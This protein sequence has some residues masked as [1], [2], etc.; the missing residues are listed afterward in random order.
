MQWEKA[1]RVLAATRPAY[2]DDDLLVLRSALIEEVLFVW[3][4]VGAQDPPPVDLSAEEEARG[5][6]DALAAAIAARERGG[7]GL[8]P[9]SSS[10]IERY[11]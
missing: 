7:G 10:I 3:T 5:T 2:L 6:V 11:N 1:A 8:R 4:R 9:K